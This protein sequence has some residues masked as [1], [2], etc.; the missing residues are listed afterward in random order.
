MMPGS[1][2]SVCHPRPLAWNRTIEPGWMLVS[3]WRWI[4]CADW[5]K[6]GS[7]DETSHWIGSKPLVRGFVQRRR[8]ASPIRKAKEAEPPWRLLVCERG[9]ARSR[10]LLGFE[11]LAHLLI[12]D[13]RILDFVDERLS[14]HHSQVP[15]FPSVVCDFEQRI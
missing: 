1:A 13:L 9:A 15:M 10:A 14:R 4:A 5:A 12:G 6:V 11:L 3:T 8:A 7:S 2:P